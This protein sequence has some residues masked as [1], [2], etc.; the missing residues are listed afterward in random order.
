MHTYYLLS[1]M[2]PQ[3]IENIQLSASVL[4]Y[5]EKDPQTGV[6]TRSA[7]M[8]YA[9]QQMVD[10]PDTEYVIIATD[11]A[12]FKRIIEVYG[13]KVSVEIVADNAAML[14]EIMPEGSII[15][16]YGYDQFVC[17]AERLKCREKRDEIDERFQ[18]SMQCN[19]V[20]Y[21][22]KAGVCVCQGQQHNIN[23]YVEYAI[24]A[25]STIKHQY[26]HNVS[27]V[28]DALL[29]QLHRRSV[30]EENMEAALRNE[31]FQVY[32]QPKHD[33]RTGKL[34][35]A[36]AL[37]R[38]IHPTL[39]FMS[40]G[41]F[42]PVF[43]QSGF[44][45]EA[46]AFVWGKTC[47]NQRR[48]MDMGLPVVPISVN[49]SRIEF[50]RDTTYFDRR[51]ELAKRWGVPAEL[52]HI[53]MTETMFGDRMDDVVAILQK[54]RDYGFGIELDDFG[55]G[56][57]S[58]HTLVD[59]P[60]DIVKLDMSFVRQI[61]DPKKA[62]L[63]RGCVN[64]IKSMNLKIV[65]EGVETQH[66]EERIREM[67]IDVVQGYYYSRPLPAKDFEE[68]M[69]KTQVLTVLEMQ[70]RDKV[71]QISGNVF[72]YQ[73]NIQKLFARVL[74]GVLNMW[75]GVFIIDV[76]T[77]LS[78]EL[79][80]DSYFRERV[81]ES[82]DSYEIMKVY[83]ET[84]LRPEQRQPY[85]DFFDFKTMEERFEKQTRLILDLE[86]LHSGWMRSTIVPAAYDENGRLSHIMLAV[87]KIE[88][89][90]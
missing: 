42:I 29:N 80:G 23:L 61:D 63:M 86:D 81:T 5:I 45:G 43:E 66:Q 58:L 15:G 60:L 89:K 53:E 17:L 22:L 49:S 48:W 36:E 14:Q 3:N 30:I 67:D 24:A 2:E 9:T 55:I 77:G 32:Y 12:D 56:Y 54:C 79:C 57:S 87:E 69:K 7:F 25:L 90:N 31:Q 10:H 68:Y 20:S 74:G 39:G 16:R 26:G 50:T 83:T 88:G 73:D 38:W 64:L 84:S 37:I 34:V 76:R 65:A 52:M 28:D 51:M 4:S 44:I 11:I 75:K 21:T 40:P 82:V 33:V 13:D 70:A 6:Y 27:V 35:G 1:I 18:N 62:R 8:H 41:E 78:E 19:G 46:D 59:L 71:K 47:Q 85:L 72:A